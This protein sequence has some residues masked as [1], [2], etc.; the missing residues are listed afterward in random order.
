[1]TA[2]R[3][4]A[5]DCEWKFTIDNRADLLNIIKCVKEVG[6]STSNLTM[7]I[8]P[9]SDEHNGIVDT[10]ILTQGMTCLLRAKLSADVCA[11]SVQHFSCQ[12]DD[13]LVVLK[14]TKAQF[15]ICV[16]KPRDSDQVVVESFDGFNNT[17][18]SR[19]HI[20]T[21]LY[22]SPE[23]NDLENMEFHTSLRMDVSSIKHYLKVFKDFNYDDFALKLFEDKD[24]FAMALEADS[25]RSKSEFR[26]HCNKSAETAPQTQQMLEID[27]DPIEQE[28]MEAVYCESYNLELLWNFLRPLDAKKIQ[29]MINRDGDNFP[30][31]IK[32]DMIADNS[33]M[34]FMQGP[35]DKD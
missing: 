5:E 26:F 27:E 22:D 34:Y 30:L 13:I 35:L 25:D 7:R 33:V 32:V 11:E 3:K 6:G 17:F 4:R 14:S 9:P 20:S 18:S 23:F 8:N 2:K 1:M 29:I 16:Y 24:S 19:H 28:D 15:K 10:E 21:M 12:C 31:L